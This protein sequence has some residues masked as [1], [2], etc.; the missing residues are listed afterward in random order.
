MI[1]WPLLISCVSL[2]IGWW[3][4]E[5]IPRI[6]GVWMT[7]PATRPRLSLSLLPILYVEI[8]IPVPA[9]LHPCGY[10][11]WIILAR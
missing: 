10:F 8:I 6:M 4:M 7:I 9:N 5:V 11:T 1:F 2:T 3:W